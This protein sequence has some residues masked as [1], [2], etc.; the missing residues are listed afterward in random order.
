MLELFIVNYRN[1]LSC[2]KILIHMWLYFIVYFLG[3][4][5]WTTPVPRHNN[6][7][8]SYRELVFPYNVLDYFYDKILVHY[9]FLTVY[10][11]DCRLLPFIF[12]LNSNYCS[13][14]TFRSLNSWCKL[15]SLVSIFWCHFDMAR[16]RV[17]P[18]ITIWK[19][20]IHVCTRPFY[21][22]CY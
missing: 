12:T 6:V 18:L 15:Q 7:T 5:G 1:D 4:K 2:I 14:H 11:K 3:I 21:T 16:G 19:T 10:C 17:Q 20:N 8:I 13:L 22:I 9:N